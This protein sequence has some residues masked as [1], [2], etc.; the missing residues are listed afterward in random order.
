MSY[1]AIIEWD[2]KKNVKNIKKHTFSFQ[3]ANMFF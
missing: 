1:E 3:V 2:E